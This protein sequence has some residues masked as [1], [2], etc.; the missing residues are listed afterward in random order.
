MLEW[1]AVRFSI[2]VAEQEDSVEPLAKRQ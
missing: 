2:E 1:P